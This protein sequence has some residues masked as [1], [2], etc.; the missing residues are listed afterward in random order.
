MAGYRLYRDGRRIAELPGDALSYVDTGLKPSTLY[1][2][3]LTA[4]GAG[5]LPLESDWSH[6]AAD[7]TLPPATANA[8][9]GNEY[10]VVVV[11]ATPGGIGAALAASRLGATVAL[12]EPSRWIGGMMAGGLSNTD[13][14]FKET[15]GSVVKEFAGHVLDYYR[16]VY[17][18]DSRQVRVAIGGYKFE[19]RVARAVLTRMVAQEP[20]I[21]LYRQW[22]ATGVEK[23]GNRV[24]VT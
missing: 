2:Y 3:R 16:R 15:H 23:E 1:I 11:G 5:D 4:F 10:D 22:R 6:P 18:P 13:Y 12:V 7:F 9:R 8:P 21:S 14:R 19:P 20:R 24:A 17:G